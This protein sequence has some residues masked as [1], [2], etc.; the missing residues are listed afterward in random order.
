MKSTTKVSWTNLQNNRNNLVALVLKLIDIKYN[1]G[2]VLK[3][4]DITFYLNSNYHTNFKPRFIGGLLK[5]NPNKF[6]IEKKNCY[7]KI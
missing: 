2:E 7:R 4:N 5:T 1:P 6:V 3:S